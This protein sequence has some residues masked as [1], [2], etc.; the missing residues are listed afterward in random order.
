MMY[1]HLWML[2]TL[3]TIALISSSCR[4]EGNALIGSEDEP[5]VDSNLFLKDEEVLGYFVAQSHVEKPDFAP[6]QMA[7]EVITPE[8]IGKVKESLWELWRKANEAATAEVGFEASETGKELVWEIP[9]EERMKMRLIPKDPK[10]EGGYPLVINLHGGGRY[11]N[12]PQPWSSGINED[13]WRT[14]L[15]MCRQ[16][17][18]GIAAFFVVPRMSDD[19]K[20]RWYFAPQIHAFK[21]LVKLAMLSDNIDPE[22][23]YLTGISEG[24]YGTLRLGMFMPDYFGA[25]GVLAAAEPLK[26]QEINLRHSAFT[27]EV[28]END[29]GFARNTYAYQW[30]DRL[31]ELKTQTPE[32]YTHRVRIQKGRGHGINYFEALPWMLGYRRQVDVDN[33]SYLYENIAPDYQ[34]INGRFSDGVYFLDFRGL[35]AQSRSDRMLIEVR[36]RGNSYDISSEILSGQISGKIGLFVDR[37]DHT[38]PVV[39]RLNGKVVYNK[40]VRATRGAVAE[41]IVLYGDPKRIY[42]TLIQVSL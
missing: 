24:G 35:K 18:A 32:A 38:K 40:K 39:V 25:L 12:E 21:R 28:G 13:E 36:K 29:F 10:P 37:I 19:R 33:V 3:M 15:S 5:A 9:Q 26:G 7:R 16:D 30:E 8:E 31:K 27:M 42:T 11:P 4:D 2:G 20:G 41:S 14:L 34:D 1:R 6:S 22:R 23:I 17:Y